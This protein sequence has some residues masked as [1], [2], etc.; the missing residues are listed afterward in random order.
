MRETLSTNDDTRHVYSL[1]LTEKQCIFDLAQSLQCV[2]GEQPGERNMTHSNTTRRHLLASMVLAS[3]SLAGCGDDMATTEEYTAV[4]SQELKVTHAESTQGKDDGALTIETEA[5]KP[6]HKDIPPL[7]DRRG[8]DTPPSVRQPHRH[9]DEVETDARDQRPRRVSHIGP[10][11]DDHRQRGAQPGESNRRVHEAAQEDRHDD[12]V[13][14][15]SA[16][17]IQDHEG[18]LHHRHMQ[19]SVEDVVQHNMLIVPITYRRAAVVMISSSPMPI[20][21]YITQRSLPQRLCTRS[22]WIRD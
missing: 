6:S 14:H 1:V 20:S 16:D 12:C 21:V 17:L 4:L 2:E 15:G 3:F 18:P 7:S 22:F 9:D 19:D 11:K 5:L 13:A 8:F 10:S